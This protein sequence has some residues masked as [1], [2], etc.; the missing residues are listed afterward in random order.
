MDYFLPLVGRNQSPLEKAHWEA[1][2]TCCSHCLHRDEAGQIDTEAV[3]GSTNSRPIPVILLSKN[4]KLFFN[5]VT[6]HLEITCPEVLGT[7]HI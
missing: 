4:Y 1:A 7:L 6:K 5:S 3:L 2:G